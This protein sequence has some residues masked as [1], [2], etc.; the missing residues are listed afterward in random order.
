M[1]GGGFADK[2]HVV[3]EDSF[4]EKEKKLSLRTVLIGI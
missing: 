2:K 1:G 4:S 3:A